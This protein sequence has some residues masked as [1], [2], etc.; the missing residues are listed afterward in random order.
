ML[1]AV[2]ASEAL[3]QLTVQR[4]VPL[5]VGP[6]LAKPIEGKKQLTAD[7]VD[8]KGADEVEARGNVRLQSPRRQV[9]SEWM[10]Y[11]REDNAEERVEAKGRVRYR[12]LYDLITGDEL[13]YRMLTGLGFI[14]QPRFEFKRYQA[15]GRA[16]TLAFT[17]PEQ[18]LLK[19]ADYT[20]CKGDKPAWCLRMRELAI[21]NDKEVGI[22][23]DAKVYFFDVPVFYWPSIDFPLGR[24][25]KSGFLAP[26][27]SAT[28]VRGFEMSVPWYWNIAD[29]FDATFTP[30]YMTKR[31]LQLNNQFRYL[32]ETGKSELN[33]ELLPRDTQLS[34]FRY[35]L[36]GKHEHRL[37]GLATLSIDAAKVSDDA[38][39]RDLSDRI[40]TT[41][42]ST[43]PRTVSLSSEVGD[44]GVMARV[45]RYQTLQDPA[46]PITPP[47]DRA[48]QLLVNRQ[49][50]DLLGFELNMAADYSRFIHPSL[51]EGDRLL[52]T[53]SISYP[54]RTPYAFVTPKFTY[55]FTDYNIHSKDLDYRDARRILPIVSVDSGLIFERETSYFNTRYLQTLEPRLF[56]TRTPYKKQSSIPNFDSAVADFNFAQL[57]A[58]NRYVGNDR[59]GDTDQLTL[60]ATTRFMDAN[61]GREQ[62]RLSI[63]ERLYFTDQ[64][65]NLGELVRENKTSDVLFAATGRLGE[66]WA[67]DGNMQFN[68]RAGVT[69]RLSATIRYQPAERHAVTASYRFARD[70]GSGTGVPQQVKSVDIASQWTVFNNWHLMGRVNYTIPEKKVVEGIA[71]LEYQGDCWVGRLVVQRTITAQQK[72]TNSI[73]WQLDLSGLSRVGTSPLEVLKRNIPGYSVSNDLRAQRRQFEAM[74]KNGQLGSGRLFDQEDSE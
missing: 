23:K 72:V 67:F 38:Y 35:G 21:D 48:P 6:V 34:E 47:Y 54:W 69:E 65:V 2:C 36:H 39:F 26:T 46:L 51:P 18:Y 24:E 20:T 41:S 71:G 16:D 5:S 3:A 30:R 61:T 14:T 27:Y 8:G 31:G 50:R 62:L 70:V 56:Y 74:E 11:T 59:I 44:W 25:R 55:H 32:F 29:N 1:C 58:E 57:F 13:D 17:G 19:N 7:E 40:S 43:L 4:L 64:K 15:Y 49:W 10:R 12:T 73:F 28:G 63:G 66:Q 37:F 33:A 22:A 45:L 68:T 53:P 60:A 9:R 52:F 42:I